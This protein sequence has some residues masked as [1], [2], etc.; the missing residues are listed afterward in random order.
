MTAVCPAGHTSTAED[1]CDVCGMPIEAADGGTSPVAAQPGTPGPTQPAAQPPAAAGGTGQPCPNCGTENASDALFCESC[2]YDFTTG[3][4]P[5]PEA[6]PASGP[7]GPDAT[8]AGPDG[9]DAASDPTATLPQGEHLVPPADHA[10][11]SPPTVA[12][13][14]RSTA[15]S[16]PFRWVVEMWIDP[17]WYDAQE[18]PDTLPSPGLPEIVPLRHTSVL[19]G[20]TSTSRNIHPEIDCGGDSGVS[21][22]QAQLTSDGTRW[23]VEDLDSANGTFVGAASGALPTDPIAVGSKRELDPD[24]RVYIGAWTRL[25]IRE[26]TE[27]ELS[28][29]S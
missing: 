21:R 5:R 9:P 13:D 22:R 17:A 28:T 3:S 16:L 12:G 10:A 11:A 26:A 7:D 29:L 23:F 8:G 6:A 25:V 27:D 1:Y 19:V 2:G 15:P 14:S 24:D 18:S 20:R 4:L